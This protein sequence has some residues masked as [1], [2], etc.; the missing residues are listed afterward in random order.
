MKSVF[1]QQKH[2]ELLE[3]EMWFTNSWPNKDGEIRYNSKRVGKK[4]YD[5]FGKEAQ[6][7]VPVFISKEEYEQAKEVSK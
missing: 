5:K 4:A 3:G 7:L 2:P 6:D 1:D